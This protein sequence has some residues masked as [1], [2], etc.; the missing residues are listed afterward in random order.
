[1]NTLVEYIKTYPNWRTELTQK[2]YCLTIKEKGKYTIF[3]YSQIDSDFYNKIVRVSRGIILKDVDTDPVVVCHAF[4]KFGNYGESYADTIDWASARV[5]EK[6][7]GSIIR[8][9]HDDDLWHVSTNN[10]IDAFETDLQVPTEEAK[11]FGELFK[12]AATNTCGS[13][14]D[15]LDKLDQGYTYIFELTS[16]WN[17]VVVPYTETTITHIGSRNRVT[18]LEENIDLGIKKPKEYS[19]STFEDV[20]A[21]AAALPFSQEGYVVVDKNWHRVKVKSKMYLQIHHLKDNGNV[22]PKRV[23]E[24]VKTNEQDE[25]LSYFPEYSEY[26]N[27]IKERWVDTLARIR[28]AVA[29]TDAW[30]KTL[31]TKKDFAM[32]VLAEDIKLRKYMFARWDGKDIQKLI[33][34][35]TYEDLI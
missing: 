9:W 21:N 4:D 33:D 31:P 1:M 24:L 2:P 8:L 30:K 32:K 12:I 7:D 25:F 22:N 10:T 28:A 3:S 6:V 20:I 16:P 35:I 17:R 26:F 29:V 11:S 27:K 34:E 23:L 18:D 13:Y 19:F 15:L 14:S 5:Q